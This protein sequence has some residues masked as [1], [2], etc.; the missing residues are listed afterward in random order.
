MTSV[1]ELGS[2]EAESHLMFD[3]NYVYRLMP[4][5]EACKL[6][7]IYQKLPKECLNKFVKTNFEV[8]CYYFGPMTPGDQ[9]IIRHDKVPFMSYPHEWCAGTLK[10]ACLFQL[11]L[12]EKLL[13]QELCLKDLHPW[14]VML[15]KGEFVHVDLPSV[16]QLSALDEALK[17]P[18]SSHTEAFQHILGNMFIP[19]FFMPLLGYAYG[20]REWIR[21]RFF[22]STLNVGS[23]VIS[24][25]DL[26][27]ERSK[28][29]KIIFSIMRLS[30]QYIK[31]NLLVK[32]ASKKVNEKVLKDLICLVQNL[33]V[34]IE[35][36]AYSLYYEEKNEDQ[37]LHD[38]SKWNLKQKHVFFAL[39][40]KKIKTV[41]DVA[42][43]AGWFSKL[44]ESLGKKVV[45][46]DNDEGSIEKLYRTV[47]RDKLNIVPICMSLTNMTPNRYN[48]TNG[49][50]TLVE[51]RKRLQSDCVLVLGLI[52]HLYLGIGGALASWCQTFADLSL[53]RL[54]L[55][56]ISFEDEKIVENPDFFPAYHQNPNEFNDY[57]LT[58]VCDLLRKYFKDI[59]ILESSS[60]TRKII[61][62]DR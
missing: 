56:F 42:C 2:C 57:T 12:L 34:E 61:V 1:L 3:E 43:N 35:Q 31:M 44:A 27:P 10:D 37:G 13:H 8:D 30:I 18:N 50:L 40:D 16:V 36:S 38:K 32:S 33:P 24:F 39:D 41:C 17:L 52:H 23:S 22:S 9:M 49:M 6:Q 25:R 29:P 5:K 14:N 54:V 21:I 60:S 59:T 62:A 51:A 47:K 46:F 19:Y 15:E 4:K 20:K 55:E 53:K 48:P 7:D 26:L 28:N 58:N 11:T 45:A